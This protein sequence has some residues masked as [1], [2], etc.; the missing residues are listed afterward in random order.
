MRIRQAFA[1][2]LL[3]LTPALT[4]CLSLSGLFTHT[5]SV[6]KTRLPDVVLNSSLDQLLKQTTDRYDAVQSLTARI[7][8][9]VKTGG[10][11]KGA[12]TDTSDFHGYII[13]TKPQQIRMIVLFPLGA[14]TLVDMV[15]DGKTFKMEIPHYN[16][17]ILGSDQSQPSQKGIYALRPAVILDSLLIQGIGPDQVVSMTQDSWTPPQPK[18]K[19]GIVEDPDYDIEFLSQPQGQN[20]HTLRVVHIDRVNLLPWQQDIY[21]ADGKVAT[22]AFYSNYQK[23]GD[24]N[25]PTKIVIQRPLDDLGLTITVTTATFNQ[26][27]P[28][29]QFKLPIPAGDKITNLDDPANAT[30]TDPCA[31]HGTQSPH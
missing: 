16:C 24:I 1:T 6:I 2:G 9:S 8:V 10:S 18:N 23:F 12:V 17:A 30:V 20:A 11:M 31:V 3:A 5:H 28:E 21:N 19:K 15:S 25:F 29:D 7:Q 27:L 13:L 22:Q 4:G 26:Q 14:G